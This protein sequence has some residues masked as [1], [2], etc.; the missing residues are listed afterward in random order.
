MYGL[1]E[2]LYVNIGL[3]VILCNEPHF[4]ASLLVM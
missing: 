2:R 3:G 1:Y 4:P